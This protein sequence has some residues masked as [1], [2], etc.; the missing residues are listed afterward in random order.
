MISILFVGNMY[1]YSTYCLE[2]K[3]EFDMTTTHDGGKEFSMIFPTFGWTYY[4][5]HS[6]GK[7]PLRH[8][9]S[10]ITFVP[11]MLAEEVVG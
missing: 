9:V 8:R 6:A 11:H 3:I 4:L 7:G 1:W 10:S 5:P 2:P